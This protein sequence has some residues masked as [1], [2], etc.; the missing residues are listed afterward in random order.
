MNLLPILEALRDF[1]TA[2]LANTIGYI[3]TTPPHEYYMGGSIQ[4]VTPSLGPTVGIAVTC[5]I[6]TSTPGSTPDLDGYFRQ[7]DEISDMNVSAVWVAR[8]V[9]SRPDHECVM[10]DGMGKSLFAAG[11]LGVVTD[12]GVRDVSGLLSI[13]FAAYCKGTTIHHCALRIQNCGE[14]VEIGGITI[15]PGDVIHANAEGVIRIPP[16]CLEALPARAI[17]MR[18]FEHAAHCVLRRTDL[19]SSEKRQ[20]VGQLLVEYGF[21][22]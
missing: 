7:L 10:G 21:V 5:E 13:P 14:P 8:T 11:C 4:S 19:K 22:K 3:D 12:G 20:R 15:R 17:Q 9:G 18:A 6:D 1:D 16:S 2:L